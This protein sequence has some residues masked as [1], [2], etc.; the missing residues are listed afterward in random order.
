MSVKDLYDANGNYLQ[1]A[2]MIPQELTYSRS[3]MFCQANGMVLFEISSEESKIALLSYAT[4][5]FDGVEGSTLYVKGRFS[6]ECWYFDNA[7]GSFEAHYGYCYENFH[8]FCEFNNS[9]PT[10]PGKSVNCEYKL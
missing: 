10:E 2:C 6:G 5:V 9:A 8:S 4:E 3:E 7:G 1:S